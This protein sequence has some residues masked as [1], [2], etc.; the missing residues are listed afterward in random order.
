MRAS[1]ADES[2]ADQKTVAVILDASAVVV[3]KHARRNRVA[4]SDE[5]LSENICDV[6]VLRSLVETIQSAVGIFFELMKVCEVELITIVA[7]SAEETHA[8]VIIRIDE[9]AKAGHEG[10][11]ARA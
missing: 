7:E 8:Q 2:G 6:N 5:I 4:F 11:N 9:A 3:E 10:T 1:V